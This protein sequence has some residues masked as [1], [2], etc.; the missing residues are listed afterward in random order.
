M[1]LALTT[2]AQGRSPVAFAPEDLRDSTTQ[3]ID[4]VLITI[5]NAPEWLVKRLDAAFDE[6]L[7]HHD[8]S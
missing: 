5:A 7:P 2:D 8:R 6:V 4:G 3:I 1:V